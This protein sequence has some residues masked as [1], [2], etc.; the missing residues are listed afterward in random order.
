MLHAWRLR[1][2]LQPWWH[3]PG[4]LADFQARYLPRTAPASHERGYIVHRDGAPFAF[5]Q[6]YVVMA[7]GDGW[8]PEET[9]PGA[10]GID[11]FIAHEADLGRGLGSAM[12]RAFVTQLFEDAA[13]TQVQTDPEPGNARAIA[14]YRRAGFVE[15]GRVVT[16]DGEALLMVCTRQT[17]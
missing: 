14:S 12:V 11:Q 13:I 3:A 9:D 15:R 2:H 1:A 8:W 7:V 17:L 5:M 4:T 10:R 6:S 16:P